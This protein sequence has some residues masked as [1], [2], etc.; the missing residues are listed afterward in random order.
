MFHSVSKIIIRWC[1][2]EI[3]SGFRIK[4]PTIINFIS[5]HQTSQFIY[6][7]RHTGSFHS[8]TV[9]IIFYF[10]GTFS[11]S[12]FCKIV[13]IAEFE[14]L[15]R[16]L[17]TLRYNIRSITSICIHI[18]Q[19][20]YSI[21]CRYFGHSQLYL[22]FR[23]GSQVEIKCSGFNYFTIFQYF[24]TKS[25]ALQVSVVK[26]IRHSNQSF[27]GLS[28]FEINILIVFFHFQQS[29]MR[30]SVRPNKPIVVEVLIVC[31]ILATHVATISPIFAS[32]F[33]GHFKSLIHP[34]PD[35]SAL[36]IFTTTNNVPVFFEIS[37]AITHSMSIFTHDKRAFHI[38]ACSIFLHISYTW[39][40]RTHHVGI[41]FFVCL[42]K[43][44][45][46]G[47]VAFFNPFVRF[48][49]HVTIATLIP[50][51]PKDNGR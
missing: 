4:V 26:F 30:F 22:L 19:I 23:L 18:Q 27:F 44:Y 16:Y 25:V 14:L 34:V 40:H 13:T 7:H 46:S 38:F 28:G 35:K 36:H 20:F 1:T 2:P 15:A 42:F 39:I 29:G 31:I 6:H 3:R 24:V 17:M 37:G 11:L 41:F 33:V 12:S 8:Y 49:K 9:F 43:L 32:C 21:S 10:Y 47:F 5:S 51:R 48:Q 45:Q 50:K